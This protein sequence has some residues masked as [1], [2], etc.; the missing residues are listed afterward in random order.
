MKSKKES[1]NVIKS[2]QDVNASAIR[3]LA[4]CQSLI[5]FDEELVGDPLEKACL[6]WIDWNVTKRNFVC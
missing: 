4:A 3:V 2:V 5:R 1:L 6:K